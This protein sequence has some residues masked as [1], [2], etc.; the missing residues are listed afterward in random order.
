MKQRRRCLVTGCGRSGT[1][2]TARLLR[3]HGVD[4]GHEEVRRD[5]IASWCMAVNAKE[6]PWGPGSE[7]FHFDYTFHQ[8]RHPLD[9]MASVASFRPSSWSFIARY[10]PL[11]DDDSAA[12]RAGRYW[13][14][15]NLEAEKLTDRRYRVEDV[16]EMKDV[17]FSGLGIEPDL[18]V[19][20]RLG[21]ETNTRSR[22]RLF[23]FYQ[24]TAMRWN[25][26]PYKRLTSVFSAA[27]P[28]APSH[29]DAVWADLMAQDPGLGHAISEKAGEYGYSMA[30]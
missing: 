4:I 25:I 8:V 29:R 1:K 30:I 6:T 26:V 5:G 21:T 19:I 13:L 10:L 12:V 17:L 2:H 3:L 15:W 20:D 28:S 9:V 16:G 24:E 27:Q 7:D 22:G 18:K 11:R 23:H 14:G